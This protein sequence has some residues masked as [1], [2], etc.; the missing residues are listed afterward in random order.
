MA[1]KPTKRCSASLIITKCKATPQWDAIPDL[2]GWLLSEKE[3]RSRERTE[4][5]IWKEKKRTSVGKD[6]EQWETLCAVAERDVEQW[7]TLCAVDGTVRNPLRCG[8]ESETVQHRGDQC[9]G[10]AS[11]P[12]WLSWWSTRLQCRRPGL[13][14][15][16]GKIPWRRKWQPTPVFLPG[17]SHG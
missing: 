5:K 17:E 7:E 9:G 14:S 3:G 10:P 13:D 11:A 4:G 16:A 6:M 12:R 2:S 15:W 8:W 1:N